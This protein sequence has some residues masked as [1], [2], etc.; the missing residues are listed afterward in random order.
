ML[1]DSRLEGC[2]ELLSEDEILRADRFRFAIHRNRFMAGRAALRILMGGYTGKSPQDITF[3]YTINGKPFIIDSPKSVTFNVS[4]SEDLCLIAVGAFA[5]IGVDV[6]KITQDRE[7]EDIAKRFFSSGEAAA[8]NQLPVELRAAAFFACWT[9]KEAFV[10]AHGVG[11]VYGLDQF[12]VST[13]PDE[14]ARVLSIDSTSEHC[15]GLIDPHEWSLIN[16]KVDAGYAGALAVHG[17]VQQILE[18]DWEY[19]ENLGQDVLV[20]GNIAQ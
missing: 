13:S 20:G 6:E 14:P 18:H 16:L 3:G 9:R 4:N 5:L 2:R 7:L 17:S 10:K 11:L 8:I 19:P 15:K 1:D 12:E